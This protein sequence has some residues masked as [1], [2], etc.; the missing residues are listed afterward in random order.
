[1]WQG[2][3]PM[4]LT[5]KN[6]GIVLGVIVTVGGLIGAARPVL[7]SDPPPLASIARVNGVSS[8][9][10]AGHID[11]V[12]RDY[13]ASELSGNRSAEIAEMRDV[14][15]LETEYAS[16]NDGKAWPLSPCP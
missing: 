4:A 11:D 3:M 6:T 9:V 7:Q 12:M 14:S 10:I 16:L 5:W 13:C 1:M 8:E 2:V 15:D